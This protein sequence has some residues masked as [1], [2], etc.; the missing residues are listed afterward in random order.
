M[1]RRDYNDEER[2]LFNN[3]GYTPRGRRF[4]FSRSDYQNI[5]IS[6]MNYDNN[7]SAQ[8]GGF[9]Q[10][11]QPEHN[12]SNQ[13]YVQNMPTANNFS[14]QNIPQN[15]QMPMNN[16]Y[17]PTP[18]GYGMPQYQNPNNASYQQP[19]FNN[20]GNGMNMNN[21][22]AGIPQQMD[23]HKKKGLFSKGKKHTQQVP[24]MGEFQNI[25]IVKPMNITD[26]QYIIDNLRNKQAVI[27]QFE[28]INEK[29]TQRTLDYLNG[30]IYALGGCDQRI[31]DSMFLYT[32]GGVSIQG[33]SSLNKKY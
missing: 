21:F 28:K 7:P 25:L 6:N 3:S 22:D 32:P 5:D 11:Y 12:Y 9:Q 23:V 8:N 16:G 15:N 27:V 13:Q 31:N 30:A 24:Q 14:S 18:Q 33:P 17:A 26:I 10:P 20:G 2:D 29:Y 4:N 19:Y 1:D